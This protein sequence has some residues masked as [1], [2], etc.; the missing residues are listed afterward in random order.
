M[1]VLGKFRKG[2]PPQSGSVQSG[3]EPDPCLSHCHDTL[4][5]NSFRFTSTFH[6]AQGFLSLLSS[7]LGVRTEGGMKKHSSQPQEGLKAVMPSGPPPIKHNENFSCDEL[8]AL[9]EVR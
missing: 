3:P 2:P 4:S 1:P 7:N 9:I 6:L 5:N 8:L